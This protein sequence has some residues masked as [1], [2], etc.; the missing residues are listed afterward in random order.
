MARIREVWAPNLESEMRNI[1]EIIDT[2]PYIA[3]VRVYFTES[4]ALQL[5]ADVVLFF[6]RLYR[7]PAIW[8][9]STWHMMRS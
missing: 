9:C 7:H 5:E 6:H 3:L 2:Y 1:R 4:K 8:S